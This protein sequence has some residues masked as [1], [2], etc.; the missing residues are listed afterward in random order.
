MLHRFRP[1]RGFAGLLSILAAASLSSSQVLAQNAAG[2]AGVPSPS[3]AQVGAELTCPGCEDWNACTVDTCDTA[4]GTCRH[5]PLSCDDG[6]ACTSDECRSARSYYGAVGGCF[7]FPRPDATPC[8][9]GETCTLG[10]H[11]AAGVC[12]AGAFLDPGASCDDGN[13]C[14]VS[15]ACD[16]AH[17]QGTPLG[18]GAGCDDRNACTRDDRCV[19]QGDTVVCEGTAQDCSD[20][21]LCTQDRCDPSTGACQHPPVDCA[22]GNSCTTDA[23]DPATGQCRRDNVAG[24][25]SD[26]RV[27]TT[28]ETCT[29]GNCMGGGPVVCPQPQCGSNVCM[30]EDGGCRLRDWGGPGCPSGGTCYSYECINNS[31]RIV[32]SSGGSCTIPGYCG[33]AQ[34]VRGGCQPTLDLPCED[35]NPCTDDL[36][37]QGGFS[38]T[39]VAKAD[40]SPCLDCRTCQ[41]GVCGDTPVSCDDANPCTADS[42][43]PAAGCLHVPLTC[44]DGN[45]C[46]ADLC[47]APEGCQHQPLPGQVC[48]DGFACTRLDRC[49]ASQGGVMVCAGILPGC[50]DGNPCTT[51]TAV[52]GEDLCS[53]QHAPVVDPCCTDGAPVSCDDHNAC[54]VDA[55][56]GTTGECRH[57]PLVCDDANACTEDVCEPAAGCVSRSA[58]LDGHACDDLNS[59]TRNDV[60]AAGVCGGTVLADGEACDDANVCTTQ[61]QCYA[62]LCVGFGVESGTPCDDGNSCTMGDQCVYPENGDPACHGVAG[63]IGAPCD[64]RNACTTGDQCVAP[65]AGSEE[66]VC[67]GPGTLSCDDGNHCTSDS[68]DPAS[69]CVHGGIGTPNPPA[70]TCNGLDDDCDGQVDE[71][72]PFSLCTIRPYLMRDSG[73]L[74]TF[75][76]TCRFKPACPGGPAP[77]PL[78]QIGTVW[79]S[80]A[81]ALADPLD[82]VV[83]PSPM[84]DCET[85]IVDDAEKRMVNDT[86]V[87]FVFDA[88]GNGVCGTTG[89]GRPG[90]MEHLAIVPDGK[91]A[92]VCVRWATSGMQRCGAVVVKHDAATEPQPLQ[93]PVAGD[94]SRVAPEP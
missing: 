78:E 26:G 16:G 93:G 72:E 76:V 54:T 37:P 32:N 15:D 69:G 29:G 39:H 7:H 67:A 65:P 43:D 42:C 17:C 70:E 88:D 81:D 2:A 50:D 94:G 24:A 92:R 90:L 48:D 11:C 77:A 14:T 23:C 56:D 34:C 4:T 3:R 57:D 19:T 40:G 6:N 91:L 30:E 51:D 73:T 86:A 28:G 45:S 79:L 63:A 46:T 22:D 62:G 87:T 33:L 49:V 84:R 75:F 80:A 47:T 71:R 9:D 74:K 59:C 25:C 52:V 31:C 41:G 83:L 58:P 55:C 68:C 12:V 53:C 60:C 82:N 35:N 1:S 89:G 20:G 13:S 8:D 18:G 10:D 36:C 61:D 27:C 64:D 5:D 85:A 66:P 44:D 38:C 21:D